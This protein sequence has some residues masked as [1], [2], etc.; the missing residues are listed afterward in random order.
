MALNLEKRIKG[1]IPASILASMFVFN[2]MQPLQAAPMPSINGSASI[3]QG[4]SA[5]PSQEIEFKN[6]K[7]KDGGKKSERKA[8]AKVKTV[9]YVLPPVTI[10]VFDSQGNFY[11]QYSNITYDQSLGQK[12]QITIE[13]PQGGIIKMQHVPPINGIVTDLMI[14]DSLGKKLRPRAS[15]KIDLET[16]E[17]QP[18]DNPSLSINGELGDYINESM[19]VGARIIDLHTPKTSLAPPERREE[20]SKHID[21]ARQMLDKE[22]ERMVPAKPRMPRQPGESLFSFKAAYLQGSTLSIPEDDNIETAEKTGKGWIFEGLIAKP[23]YHVFFNTLHYKDDCRLPVFGGNLRHV[24]SQFNVGVEAKVL[25]IIALGAE[26]LNYDLKWETDWPD[27]TRVWSPYMEK[28]RS[29]G[30]YGG[31][32][33]ILGDFDK[34]FI[35][36]LYYYGKGKVIESLNNPSL[37]YG[38]EYITNTESI[39]DQ[40]LKVHGKFLLGPFLVKGNYMDG[41]YDNSSKELGGKRTMYNGEVLL[42]LSSLSKRLS[43]AK[44]N[45]NAGVFYHNMEASEVGLK[46]FQQEFFGPI[47]ILDFKF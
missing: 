18:G 13:I 31:A 30:I 16:H 36:A 8:D 4:Y 20:P 43:N 5:Q 29:N 10:D 11:K 38:T 46:L 39:T 17:L 37:T 12:N 6:L 35:E 19:R 7:R 1:F 22:S 47:V 25:G 24:S 42:N 28:Y 9:R 27:T 3:S 45:I 34:S 41:K 2:G 32:G 40:S 21:I 23:N 26:Y 33:L 15:E 14:Y 44:V